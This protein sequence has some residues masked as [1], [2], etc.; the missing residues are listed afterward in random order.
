MRFLFF[1]FQRSQLYQRFFTGSFQLLDFLIKALFLLT[2]RSDLLQNM[3]KFMLQLLEFHCHLLLFTALHIAAL[4]QLVQTGLCLFQLAFGIYC[5]LAQPCNLLL[6]IYNVLVQLIQ[7]T[8]ASK[9]ISIFLELASPSHGTP[10]IDNI[11][12]QSDHAVSILA[13]GRN[14]V[15]IFQ[16]TGN[17]HIPQETA[18]NSGIS[19]I[20]LNKIC[21]DSDKAFGSFCNLAFSC[22]D[23]TRTDN[24]H[25]QK[26]RSAQLTL[27]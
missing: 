25:R 26:C 1:F 16:R 22:T 23:L 7:L 3:T 24:I 6:R 12:F 14:T 17:D 11:A 8:F 5:T 27:L 10:C 21:T 20:I 4:A 19:I 9:Q 18:Y 15:C 13:T 2:R